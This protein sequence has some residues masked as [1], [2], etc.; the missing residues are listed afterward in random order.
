VKGLK[1]PLNFEPISLDKQDKYLEYFSQFPQKASD[2]SFIN[3]WG[4]ADVYGLY[5]AWSDQMVWIKQTIPNEVFWAP[6]APWPEIDWNRCFDEYLDSRAVFHRVPED[7]MVLWQEK[8]GNRI[9]IE[10][11]REHWDYLYDVN[12]LTQLGGRRF[13]KKKNLLNQFKKNYDFQFVPLDVEMIGIAMALQEDWCTWHDCQSLDALAAENLA[14]SRVLGSWEKLEGPMG[15]AILVD[16]QM[17]AYT[18]AE[19]LSKD[20]L[21]IHFEKGNVD[22]KGTYQAVNQMFLEYFGQPFKIVNREQ[23]LGEAGLRKAKLSYNP[24]D[25]LKKYRISLK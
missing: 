25:F 23:D 4:W 9:F 2:Y 12:E 5:W 3:L 13:H 11:S 20:T 8:M 6:V 24:S 17:V 7:L 18:I 1:M 14:I 21:V 19:P 15:G 16:R 22:F 10:E